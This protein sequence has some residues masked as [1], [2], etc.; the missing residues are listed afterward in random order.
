MLTAAAFADQHGLIRASAVDDSGVRSSLAREAS[1]GRLVRL[2]RGVYLPAQIWQ[3]LDLGSRYRSVIHAAV[4]G[5]LQAGELVHGVSACALWRLPLLAPWPDSVHT[6][7]AHRGGGKR[8]GQVIRHT[9]ARPHPGTLL[10]GLPVTTLARTV[11]ETAAKVEFSAGVVIADAASRGTVAHP[12]GRGLAARPPVQ[13]SELLAEAAMIPVHHGRTRALRAVAFADA[14]ADSPGES[15]VRAALHRLGTP[16]PE[17][18]T[19]FTGSTGA[20]YFVDFFWPEQSFVLE[21]DGREKYAE[22]ALRGGR[23]AEQVVYDEKLRE[24][25]LRAQVQGFARVDWSTARSPERLA[26]RLQRAGFRW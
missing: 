8:S 20:R 17:L 9:T 16:P 14:R 7:S 18:Q 25:D 21:F 19:V 23:S 10:D 13:R 26:A 22:P 6:V 1:A 24:D 4:G 2:A 11:A 3:D 5:K 12:A 15:L